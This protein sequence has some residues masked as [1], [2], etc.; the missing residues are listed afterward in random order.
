MANAPLPKITESADEL[1]ARLHSERDAERKRRLHALVLIATRAATTRAQAAEHLAVHRN[2]L[3]RWLTRYRRGGLE[4]MLNVAKPGPAPE[5]RTL[6][7]P[8]FDALRARLSD[9]KGFSGYREIQRW[10]EESYGLVVP[11]KTLH[12]I[13]RYRLGAKLK[14]PRPEHPKKA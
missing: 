11:Y 3:S 2:T 8:V 13:V 14:T 4:A 7:R 5:Q 12:A 10:L 6:T 1:R 9:P